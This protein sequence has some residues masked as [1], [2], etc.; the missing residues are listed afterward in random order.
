[1]FPTSGFFRS[2]NCPYYLSGLCERPY[3]HFRHMKQEDRPAPV[4]PVQQLSKSTRPAEPPAPPVRQLSNRSRQ[5]LSKSESSDGGGG[6]G[7]SGETRTE[8]V[9]AVGGDEYTPTPLSVLRRAKAPPAAP[10]L[11]QPSYEPTPLTVQQQQQQQQPPASS[12]KSTDATAAKASVRRRPLQLPAPKVGADTN[13]TSATVSSTGED[14]SPVEERQPAVDDSSEAKR[15]RYDS[16]ASPTTVEPSYEP[17]PIGG[18]YGDNE[19]EDNE[20]DCNDDEYCPTAVPTVASASATVDEPQQKVNDVAKG[21]E[22]GEIK[23]VFLDL[24][25]EEPP[26]SSSESASVLIAAPPVQSVTGSAPA[27]TASSTAAS[28]LQSGKAG[29]AVRRMTPSEQVARRAQQVAAN[30]AALLS[31]GKVR[32]PSVAAT[33]AA[34][35]AP[36]VAVP[37]SP[38][39][40]TVANKIPD[41]VRQ[42]YLDRLAEE[43]RLAATSAGPDPGSAASRRAQQLELE[44]YE[45]SANRNV[46]LNAVIL[47]I[48]RVR[49]SAGNS[50]NQQQQKRPQQPEE[51]GQLSDKRFYKHLLKYA[52]TPAQL[53]ENRYPPHLPPLPYAPPA[54]PLERLCVRCGA[55]FLLQQPD[56]TTPPGQCCYHYGRAYSRRVPGAGVQQIYSCCGGDLQTK[57]CSLGE[58][59]VHE[60]NVYCDTEGYRDTVA[61]DKATVSKK[62]RRGVYALDCEMIYTDAGKELARVTVIDRSLSVVYDRLVHPSAPIVDCNTRFSGLRAEQLVSAQHRLADVQDELLKL[63]YSTSILIGHSLESDLQVL[64]LRHGTVVDTSIVFPHRQGL[65]KKRALRNLASE[66]LNKIIQTG[67]DAGHDSSEDAQACMELMFYKLTEDLKKCKFSSS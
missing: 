1:M 25:G 2:H 67:G 12:S 61:P 40:G 36:V 16:S 27:A 22:G 56:L 6:G 19:A 13:R 46:Y 65:P 53:A 32:A 50:A 9:S 54:N 57:G 42:R 11:Q 38:L 41:V 8:G 66:I 33:A 29:S 4:R 10:Q 47:A 48:K 52:M 3:C 62:L 45:R 43:C 59:H 44:C 24:F 23:R 51:A 26:S 14:Y 49:A 21:G 35:S 64:K 17:T 20:D 18:C 30:P 58:R 60:Y 5:S 31:Q 15:I 34:G 7:C 55:A 63:I 28:S 37:A 39:P